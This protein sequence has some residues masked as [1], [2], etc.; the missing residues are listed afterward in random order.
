MPTRDPATPLL[1]IAATEI[2]SC[3]LWVCV[4]VCVCG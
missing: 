4:R 1:D 3:V 2:C